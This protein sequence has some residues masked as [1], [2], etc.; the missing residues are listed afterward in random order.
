VRVNLCPPPEITKQKRSSG[1][2]PKAYDLADQTPLCARI[3][4]MKIRL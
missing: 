1:P 3:R 4:W 2:I